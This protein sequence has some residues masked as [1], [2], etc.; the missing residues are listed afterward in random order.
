[1]ADKKTAPPRAVASDGRKSL[2]PVIRDKLKNLSDF[3][4]A[5]VESELGMLVDGDILER[6]YEFENYLYCA[7]LAVRGRLEDEGTKL[8]TGAMLGRPGGKSLLRGLIRVLLDKSPGGG[9]YV[10]RI[11]VPPE[12]KTLP[13]FA[14]FLGEAAQQVVKEDCMLTGGRKVPAYK[15]VGSGKNIDSSTGH[16]SK[17][18][19]AMKDRY[20]KPDPATTSAA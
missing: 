4:V 9:E 3:D 17:L 12:T 18:V 2:M 13:L 8:S 15:V 19:Q 1:M 16:L 20:P 7:F 10:M 5:A 14:G 6:G 11:Q